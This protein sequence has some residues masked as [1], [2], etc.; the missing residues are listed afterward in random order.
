MDTSFLENNFEDL[1]ENMRYQSFCK[2]AIADCKRV[3]NEFI[4]CAKD[5]QVETFNEAWEFYRKRH[6]TLSSS[7]LKTRH[8]SLR[9][10][11]RFAVNK[12]YPVHQLS[13][14]QLKLEIHS[15]GLLDLY[16]LQNRMDEFL[17]LLSA[18]GYSVGKRSTLRTSIGRIIIQARTIKW[19]TF[20]E[21]RDWYDNQELS[22]HYRFHV[23]ETIDKIECFMTNGTITPHPSIQNK[24]VE[25]IPSIGKLNLTFL[26]DN[27]PK[28][29]SYME[30]SGYGE[31]YRKKVSFIANRIVILSRSIK[32]DSYEDIWNWYDARIRGEQYRKDVRCVL[33][34]LLDF[35]LKGVMPNNRLTQNVL[36][37]RDNNYS[38]LLPQYK[39]LVDYVNDL[40]KQRGLKQSSIT[41]TKE[42]ASSF[43]RHLQNK[44][45]N[46]LNDVTEDTVLEYFFADGEEKRGYATLSNLRRF[47]TKGCEIDEACKTILIY[48]PVLRNARIT[49]QYLTAEEIKLF[50]S[51]LFDGFNKLSYKERA[52]GG[53][54]VYTPMRS[55][56]IASLTLDSFDLRNN[57]FY[58]IQEKTSNPVALTFNANLGNLIY[59]YCV[60]ERENT[61]SNQL[62]LSDDPPYNPLGEG[63]IEWAA[64]KIM[65]AAG[66]R[67]N[68]GDRQG[69]HIFRH[70]G[71]TTMAQNNVPAPVISAAM[72]QN[73]PRSLAPYLSADFVHLKICA[74]G[75]NKFPL[76]KEVFSVV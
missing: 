74:L 5:I 60:Y 54:L 7:S 44:G 58:F 61:G 46:Y 34:L 62:F 22:D 14:S 48:L 11:F 33:G 9:I 1:L 53:L 56:D 23:R 16:D 6:P 50:K 10:V 36:C 3:G 49:I 21:I 2:D 31:D 71:A 20:Q 17:S 19:D 32:W 64:G 73:S 35:H 43:L 47:L 39:S 26:Q 28:L 75:L 8:T 24:M 27:L 25:K 30:N 67:Q 29:L 69:T 72:G 18:E 65:A 51:A 40:E 63:G 4:L 57:I 76:P 13:S 70:R 68:E 37:L 42:T 12:E 66:I 55:S 41:R 45:F 38:H 15:K 59:D 52:I